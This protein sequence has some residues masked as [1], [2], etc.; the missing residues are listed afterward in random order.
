MSRE[1]Y[2]RALKRIAAIADKATLDR[3]APEHDPKSCGW[4]CAMKM[5][6]VARR[7]LAAPVAAKE[8]R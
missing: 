7:A 1:K 2:E 6:G 3:R 4:C 5:A 8:T